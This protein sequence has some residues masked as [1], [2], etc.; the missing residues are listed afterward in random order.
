M[1]KV[2]P[3]LIIF[4]LFSPLL[5]APLR[6]AADDITRPTVYVE[7]YT[8]DGVIAEGSDVT[9]HLL[10][11]NASKQA[12]VNNILLNLQPS[13]A[14]AAPAVG[15]TSQYFAE[16]IPAGET[17]TVDVRLTIYNAGGYTCDVPY[18]L[19]WQGTQSDALFSNSGMISLPLPR[20][21]EEEPEGPPA[22]PFLFV[23]SYTVDGKLSA[24]EDIVIHFIL[25][26][27][28]TQSPALNVFL[29]V[30][31][32]T[33]AFYPSAGRSNQY[34]IDSIPPDATATVDVY[35]TAHEKITDSIHDISYTISWQGAQSEVVQNGSGMISLVARS[36][37]LEFI[38]VSVPDENNE[39]RPL[40][41]SARY[42]NVSK[43]DL[44]GV[45]I[46]IEG[47][48]DEA[49]KVIDIGTARAGAGGVVENNLIF[50]G[51]GAQQ[52]VFNLVYEDGDGN[53]IIAN[54]FTAVTTVNPAPAQGPQTTQPAQESRPSQNT[55]L[56][57]R[58]RSNAPLI[59]VAIMLLCAAAVVFAVVRQRRRK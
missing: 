51:T 34:F 1:K 17:I 43:N 6:V 13:S 54:S 38:T 30:T 29:N 10:L 52:L 35:M 32:S 18:T 56:I 26:N 44:R 28:E 46:R 3:V 12:A 14:A 47:N 24:E 33:G 58:I 19:S 31:S 4:S 20:S 42:T 15:S 8:V 39:G 2:L 40:Y 59:I 5:A 9:I 23:E 41:V 49:Q 36:G 50:T 16:S 7:S 25:R 22:K 57:N 55:L 45:K 53:E 11:R 48:I 27:A 37:S 21:P